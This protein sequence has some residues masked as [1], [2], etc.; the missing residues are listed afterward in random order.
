MARNKDELGKGKD[1]WMNMQN[2]KKQIKE[3]KIADV[4]NNE[5]IAKKLEEKRAKRKVREPGEG[6]QLG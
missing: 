1:D 6:F 3:D 4:Q 2:K 5:E